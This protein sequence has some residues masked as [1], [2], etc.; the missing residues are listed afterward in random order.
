MIKVTEAEI[1]ASMSGSDGTL[2]ICTSCEDRDYVPMECDAY[3]YECPACG[4]HTW[5]SAEELMV[6][7]EIEIVDDGNG[8]EDLSMGGIIEWGT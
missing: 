5:S 6:G 3:N 1:A 2:M 7:G 4:E 8:P